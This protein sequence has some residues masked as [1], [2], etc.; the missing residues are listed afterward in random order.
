M[1]FV[2]K[3]GDPRLGRIAAVVSVVVIVLPLTLW[4]AKVALSD[5][6]GQGNAIIKKND[7]TN[8]I[9]AQERFESLYA[10]IV[11]ADRRLDVLKDALDNDPSYTNKVNFTGGQTYC[12]SVVAD[13]N[14]E[15]RKYSARDFRSFD[16]P[17]QIDN[18]DETTDCKPTPERNKQ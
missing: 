2:D 15:A 6:F 16:L 5:L 14:A 9:S 7:A 13:Y 12:L 11:N 17:A 8:R 3:Y 18:W 4:G 10:E 1:F